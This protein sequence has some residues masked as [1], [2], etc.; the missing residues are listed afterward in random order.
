MSAL[1]DPSHHEEVLVSPMYL[2]GSNGTGD[3]GF[4]PVAHWPHHYLDDGPCQLLVTSPDQRIRIGWFGDDFELWRIT[5]AEDAVA[6][7]RWTATFNHVTPAEIVAGLTTALAQD[8]AASDPYENNGR[9]LADPSL[10]WADAVQPLLDAGWRRGAAKY[11]TV[12]VTAPD[13]LAGVEIHTLRGGRDAEAV[14]LWAGPRGWG[15]RAEVVFTARTPSH[16]IA[17]TA[18]VMAGS[19]PVVRERHMIHREMEPLVT[20]TPVGPAADPRGSRSPTPLDVR[21]TAVTEA[22]RRAACVPRPAAD[23]RVMAAQ[24]RTTSSAQKRSSTLA[25]TAA[26]R[27]SAASSAPRHSR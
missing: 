19:A 3:A 25:P 21:R 26:A 16:L 2:A 6:T 14:V 15:T 7:P 8:Y 13:G 11:G 27:P 24:S 20:L 4:A 12:E 22:V 17:A 18:A 1:P 5:V 10:Y 23:L 9:F